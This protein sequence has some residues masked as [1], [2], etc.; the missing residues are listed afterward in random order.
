MSMSDLPAKTGIFNQI[1]K[2]LSPV[3]SVLK[4][5][6]TVKRFASYA[7]AFA[8]AEAKVLPSDYL[9]KVLS[10]ALN[11]LDS[12]E[13]VIQNNSST[14]NEYTV[15][16]DRNQANTLLKSLLIN[17]YF[18]YF[19]KFPYIYLAM[20]IVSFVHKYMLNI[21]ILISM[22]KKNLNLQLMNRKVNSNTKFLVQFPPSSTVLFKHKNN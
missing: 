22:I 9:C 21:Q 10:A 14:L 16:L 15:L 12:A 19:T 3:K 17:N 11:V 5:V 1:T 2:A 4:K 13:D 18:S 7:E 20:L 8:S 6:S